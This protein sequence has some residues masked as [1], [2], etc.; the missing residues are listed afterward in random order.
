MLFGLEMMCL[1]LENQLKLWKIREKL[2][3]AT[4]LY[5]MF[6]HTGR[7]ARTIDHR[8]SIEKQKTNYG[9]IWQRKN[10]VSNQRAQ[11]T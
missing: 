5:M 4:K 3:F 6:I 2:S 8:K 10:A 9:E 1:P 7:V 11:I